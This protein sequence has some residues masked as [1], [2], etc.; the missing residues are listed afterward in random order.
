MCLFLKKIAPSFL[1]LCATF[2]STNC[3]NYLFEYYSRN[4]DNDNFL[5]QFACY[6]GDL[7]IISKLLFWIQKPDCKDSQGLRINLVSVV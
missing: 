6:G 2:S 7:Q 1:S 4:N 5:K 3:F